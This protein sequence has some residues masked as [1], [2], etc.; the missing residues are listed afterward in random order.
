MSIV[1]LFLSLVTVIYNKLIWRCFSF[2]MV[3]L[4][5]GDKLLKWSRRV[6]MFVLSSF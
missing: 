1:N 3:S 4:R 6:S 2:P 5:L